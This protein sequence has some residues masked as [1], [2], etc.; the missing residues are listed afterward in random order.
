MEYHEVR[1]VAELRKQGEHERAEEFRLKAMRPT[2]RR[3]PEQLVPLAGTPSDGWPVVIDSC[4]GVCGPSNAAGYT[5]ARTGLPTERQGSVASLSSHEE[6]HWIGRDDNVGQRSL[7][8]L[9]F[10]LASD[11]EALEFG[12]IMMKRTVAWA[13]DNTP[14][15]KVP[16]R[17]EEDVRLQDGRYRRLVQWSPESRAQRS[18]N[19]IVYKVTYETD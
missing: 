6:A 7:G 8:L 18:P 14:R 17:L 4:V 12:A 15:D 2:P 16:D 3:I 13:A 5:A 1:I 9:G 19:M 11:A 10:G